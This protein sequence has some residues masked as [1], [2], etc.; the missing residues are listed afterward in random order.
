MREVGAAA[1]HQTDRIWEDVLSAL[2]L[3]PEVKAQEYGVRSGK[4]ALRK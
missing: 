3:K 1:K 4:G 2:S